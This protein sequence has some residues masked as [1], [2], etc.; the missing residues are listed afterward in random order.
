MSAA[1][2]TSIHSIVIVYAQDISMFPIAV[3]AVVRKC[4]CTFS[5]VR[6]WNEK[7]A[8]AEDGRKERRRKKNL[9]TQTM[10]RQYSRRQ[11]RERQ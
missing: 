8:L 2:D 1:G 11:N 7:Q 5:S 9:A 3:I 10:A 4:T 6:K